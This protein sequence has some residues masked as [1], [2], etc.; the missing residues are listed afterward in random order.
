M[1]ACPFLSLEQRMF[2]AYRNYHYQMETR[3]G[4]RNLFQHSTHEGRGPLQ[5]DPIRSGG[6]VRFAPR[7]GGYRYP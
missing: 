7:E 1:Y 2:T 4:M 6:S 5:G 3:P